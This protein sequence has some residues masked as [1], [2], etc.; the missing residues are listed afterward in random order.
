MEKKSFWDG[1]LGCFIV[2]CTLIAGIVFLLHTTIEPEPV[3]IQDVDTVDTIDTILNE[4]TLV[5]EPTRNDTI[6]AMAH[7]FAMRESGMEHMA[8]SPCGRY[9]G[10]LQLSKIM[11]AEANR[12]LGWECFYTDEHQDDR[13]DR[14]GSLAVFAIVQ[15]YHNPKLDIDRA[16]TI[17]NKNCGSDYRECVKN[18]YE[19]YLKTIGL[20]NYFE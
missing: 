18:L 16:I 15:N 14:Q 6:V 3:N 5:W 4:D 10:C 7:A 12:I 17:W 2:I 11:V 13:L 19:D 1:G 20:N 9:V 8:V